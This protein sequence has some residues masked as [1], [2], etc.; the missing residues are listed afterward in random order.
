M[1]KAQ[2]DNPVPSDLATHC[3][4][5]AWRETCRKKFSFD[6]KTPVKCADYTRDVSLPSK[7]K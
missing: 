2:D 1:A 4:V 5:C 7:E 6:P 3:G